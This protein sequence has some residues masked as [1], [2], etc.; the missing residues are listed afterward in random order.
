MQVCM[1]FV[2]KGAYWANNIFT[3]M[4]FYSQHMGSGNLQF[5][6]KIYNDILVFLELDRFVVITGKSTLDIF[7]YSFRL[8]LW[9][10]K[11][12]EMWRWA[13]DSIFIFGWTI[14]LRCSSLSSVYKP[15]TYWIVFLLR[16]LQNLV[17]SNR[18]QGVS[19]RYKWCI[20]TN[21][22]DVP[23]VSQLWLARWVFPAP[24]ITLHL[25]NCIPEE[26]KIPHVIF[27][28]NTSLNPF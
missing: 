16:D 27:P 22:E 2:V 12:F 15:I 6:S 3:H 5:S 1:R 28:H 24:V 20:S 14:L 18:F 7:K 4:L 9:K 21:Q 11:R 19:L 26:I 23:R 13:N 25:S 8:V 17:I 10:I